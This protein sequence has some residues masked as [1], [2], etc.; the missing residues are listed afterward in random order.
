MVVWTPHGLVYVLTNDGHWR[1]FA[2]A[3]PM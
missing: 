3:A 2:D 1:T